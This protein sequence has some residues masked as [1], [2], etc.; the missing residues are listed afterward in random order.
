MSDIYRFPVNDASPRRTINDVLALFSHAFQ[1]AHANPNAGVLIYVLHRCRDVRIGEYGWRTFQGLVLSAAVAEPSTLRVA[2]DLLDLHSARLGLPLRHPAIRDVT[3]T[4][5]T[6]NARL[7]NGSEV[8]WALWAAL[9]WNVPLSRTASRE[10]GQME[11][12]FVALLALDGRLRDVVTADLDVSRWATWAAAPDALENEHWLLAFE[13]T[14]RGWL[15]GPPPAGTAPAPAYFANLAQQSVRFYDTHP[16]HVGFT[17][18]SAPFPGGF[19][20]NAS[21]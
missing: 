5:V 1:L 19:L 10:L 6:R 3:D 8:A 18:A 15:P 14:S 17:G 20:R 13:A 9:H 11:D 2:I 7:G 12:D 21:I 16:T 4:L